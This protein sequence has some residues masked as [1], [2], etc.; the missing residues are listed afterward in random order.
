[1]LKLY[2]SLIISIKCIYWQLDPTSTYYDA[3]PLYSW[4]PIDICFEYK[5]SVNKSFSPN[6]DIFTINKAINKAFSFQVNYN[7]THVR[8]LSQKIK[9]K[10]QMIFL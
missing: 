8:Y 6:L 1:M 4:K 7:I 10:S 9:P 5:M 2:E 3:M